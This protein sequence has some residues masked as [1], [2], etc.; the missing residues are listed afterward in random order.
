[1][2]VNP[3][4][5]FR[6]YPRMSDLAYAYGGSGQ[7]TAR[8]KVS[9]EDFLVEEVLGFE[10]SG[11]GEHLWLYI[12]AIDMNTDFTV[13]QLARAFGI[14]KKAISYSG[15][16]DRR[17]ITSQWF[18]LHMPGKGN[19]IPADLHENLQVLTVKRH[20]KKL[21][22]GAHK[23]N[24]FTICLREVTGLNPD[25]FNHQLQQIID[26]GYPNYFGPQRFGHNETNIDFAVQVMASGR[27]LKRQ[28]RDRVYSTLR[29]WD[30]NRLLSQRVSDKSWQ[31]YLPGDALQLAGTSSFFCP[32]AWDDDL[33]TRLNSGDLAVAGCLPGKG[34][35]RVPTG[36][37][38]YQTHPDIL[39]Y[40]MQQR[41]EQG[42]RPLSVIPKN[43]HS[44]VKVDHIQL[45]FALPKGAY[46]T[47]LLRE[48]ITLKE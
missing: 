18:S 26:N 10:L 3:S 40:L 47:S 45:S 48:L 34:N 12:E 28:E 15:K 17:A 35:Q 11:E 5:T 13:K 25:C 42:V 19:D 39:Q 37:G 9:P 14:E 24:L 6:Y 44:H 27:R 21:R 41:V 1:M 29:A 23:E 38:V 31:T 46:A 43:I 20:S 33:Q 36:D 32:D 30:F 4:E 22:R 7:A 8:L 16:K 2:P